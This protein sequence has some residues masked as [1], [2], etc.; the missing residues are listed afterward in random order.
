VLSDPAAK[1]NYLAELELGSA[2]KM[3]MARVFQA[4]EFFHKGEIQVKARKFADAVKTLDEAIKNNPDEGEYYAW[5]GYAKFFSAADKKV[6]QP[7]AVADI[8]LCIK[9]NARCAP[10]YY[11][12]GHIAKVMGDM[13]EAKKQFNKCLELNPKYTDAERE[14]RAMK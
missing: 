11:F 4:E 5:R 12:L 9:K 7:E 10:A 1:E 2:D 6:S 8:N 14:L 3:D 13:K